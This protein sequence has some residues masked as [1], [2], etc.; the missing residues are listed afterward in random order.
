MLKHAAAVAM[1]NW[2]IIPIASVGILF[3]IVHANG[4]AWYDTIWPAVLAYFI[5]FLASSIV[6]KVTGNPAFKDGRD[7]KYRLLS[8]GIKALLFALI[9][10]VAVAASLTGGSLVITPT[11]FSGTWAFVVVYII[12]VITLSIIPRIPFMKK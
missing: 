2:V 9:D 8:I 7:F 3:G 5:S 12:L 4:W 10:S 11:G 1:L 6:L